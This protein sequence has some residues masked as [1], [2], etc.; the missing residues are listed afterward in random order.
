LVHRLSA[1]LRHYQRVTWSAP[2]TRA[3]RT[4][5]LCAALLLGAALVVLVVAADITHGE[6]TLIAR[7]NTARLDAERLLTLVVDMETGVRGFA[8]TGDPIF[9]QPYDEALRQIDSVLSDLTREAGPDH[10]VTLTGLRASI[11]SNLALRAGIVAAGRERGVRAARAE[12]AE[13]EDKRRMDAFRDQLAGLQ[14]A[15][16]TRVTAVRARLRSWVFWSGMVSI[17]AGGLAASSL[18]IVALLLR[19]RDEDRIRDLQ[20]ELLHVAR[21]GAV[22]E[23]AATLVHELGQPLTA[24]GSYLEAAEIFLRQ[25]GR[26]GMSRVAEGLRNATKEASRADEVFRSLRQ[27]LRAGSAELTRERLDL[28]ELLREGA[29]LGLA[30]TDRR[31]LDLHFPLAHELPPLPGDRVRLLQVIANLVRNAAEAMVDEP[32][33]ILTISAAAAGGTVE[34]AV[35]DTGHGLPEG[36]YTKPAETLFRPFNTTKPDGMGLGLPLARRVVEEHGGRIW[37][38]PNPGGGTVFRIA[39]SLATRHEGSSMHAAE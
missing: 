4:G 31:R 36:S 39:L 10:A 9:L 19:G 11:D 5:T 23:V 38:E 14:S 1:C 16:D 26:D 32:R 13:G 34:L 37:A 20:A 15:F 8:A 17:M 22:G 28:A 18:G 27:F 25:G 2:G 6:L 30:G 29:T 21:L 35:A 33:R 7:L 24:I 12:L 3:L